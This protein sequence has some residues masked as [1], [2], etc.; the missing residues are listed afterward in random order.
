MH[1]RIGY[2]DPFPPFALSGPDGA[3]GILI[4]RVRALVTQAGLS[5]TFVPLPLDHAEA[6]LLTG[7]VDALAFKA[8]VP[9]RAATLAFS[10]PIMATGAALF[11]L[12]DSPLAAHGDITRCAGECIATPRKGPLAQLVGAQCPQARV[13]LTEGYEASL[14]AVL[15]GA[16]DAAALNVH[17]GA[18]WADTRFAGRF[19]TPLTTFARLEFAM[20][21]AKHDSSDRTAILVAA[22]DRAIEAG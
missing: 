12:L 15:D 2:D 3:T 17:A 18:H 7:E 10:R 13:L 8:I 1:L 11:A 14:R 16:A 19:R 22:L 4:E 6:A 20:A 9:E 5:C 21:F